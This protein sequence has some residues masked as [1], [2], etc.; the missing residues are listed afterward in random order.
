MRSP[1]TSVCDSQCQSI[2]IVCGNGIVQPGEGCELPNDMYCQNCQFTTCGGCASVNCNLG[3]T[4]ATLTDVDQVNCNA[5][6]GCLVPRAGCLAAGPTLANCFP[7]GFTGPCGPQL[8]ALAHTTDPATL[9][10]L[11]NDRTSIFTAPPSAPSSVVRKA[12]AAVQSAPASSDR[13]SGRLTKRSDGLTA[14]R[15]VAKLSLLSR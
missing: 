12:P 7:S 6:E 9:T 2:P 1:N 8:E 13:A 4:C 10:Q 14:A 11:I 5:L 15:S 3:H